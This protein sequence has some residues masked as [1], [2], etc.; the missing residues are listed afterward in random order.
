VTLHAVEAGREDAGRLLRSGRLPRVDLRVPNSFE[1]V[2]RVDSPTL[3]AA[4]PPRYARV[5]GAL[6]AIFPQ[7]EYE[8]T[9][10]GPRS[11]IPA[12]TVFAIGREAAARVINPGSGGPQGPEVDRPAAAIRTSQR[13]DMRANIG[14]EFP[15]PT[16]STPASAS[17]AASQVGIEFSPPRSGSIWGDEAYRAARVAELLDR[18]R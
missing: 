16:P 2:Y 5:S 11:T 18:A 17:S 4:T 8:M 9:E 3:G 13:V 14:A 1:R 12:G 7:S 10:S 6:I 15:P